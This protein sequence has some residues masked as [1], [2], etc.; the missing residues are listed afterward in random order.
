MIERILSRM[1]F[2]QRLMAERHNAEVAR[3]NAETTASLLRMELDAVKEEYR[4]EREAR[5]FEQRRLSDFLATRV[6]G[7]PIF[8]DPRPADPSSQAVSPAGPRIITGSDLVRRHRK[9]FDEELRRAC[10]PSATE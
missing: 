10:E 4:L 3:L 7:T 9:K 5:T 1:G 6:Y 2:V 8:S